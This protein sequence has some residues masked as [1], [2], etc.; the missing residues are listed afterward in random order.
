MKIDKDPSKNIFLLKKNYEHKAIANMQVDI[1]HKCV[2]RQK[3][4][5]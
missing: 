2:D 4:K 3:H 1:D 5:F